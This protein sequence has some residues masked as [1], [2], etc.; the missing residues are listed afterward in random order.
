MT[1]KAYPDRGARHVV[2]KVVDNGPG[3]SAQHL[4]QINDAAHTAQVRGRAG[5]LAAPADIRTSTLPSKPWRACVAAE[6]ARRH[7][8]AAAA[9][10]DAFSRR[11]GGLGLGLPITFQLA[12]AHGGVVRVTSPGPGG[13]TTAIL[14]LPVMQPA[15][16]ARLKD[17]FT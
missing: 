2:I 17:A 14:K 3:L 7:A 9:Q 11:A 10:I 8:R 5:P 1:V 15:T 4:A 12:A 16:D 13:G 6:F